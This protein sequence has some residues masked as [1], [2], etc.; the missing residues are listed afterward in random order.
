[1]RADEKTRT[2]L[3]RP[4]YARDDLEPRSVRLA[5]EHR[6]RCRADIVGAIHLHQPAHRRPTGLF[7]ELMSN[8]PCFQQYG[9]AKKYSA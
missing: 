3:A 6:C 7:L 9:R 2:R 5:C 8:E 1:L 4:E